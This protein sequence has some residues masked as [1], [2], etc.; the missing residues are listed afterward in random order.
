MQ[1]RVVHKLQQNMYGTSWIT[2][3]KIWVD[4]HNL[5]RG[6]PLEIIIG[7]ELIIRPLRKREVK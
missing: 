5:K 1:I 7:E 2:L 3:P 6:D 4:A